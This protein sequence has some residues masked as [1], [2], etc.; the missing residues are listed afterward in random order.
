ML[1]ILHPDLNPGQRVFRPIE[2]IWIAHQRLSNHQVLR[3]EF[4]GL[5]MTH[6]EI[7]YNSLILVLERTALMTAMC[8]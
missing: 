8:T 6:F 3:K 2:R 1:Q 7:F 5:M 4:L